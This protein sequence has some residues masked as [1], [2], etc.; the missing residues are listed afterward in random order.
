MSQIE[1]PKS[2][3]ADLSVQATLD[4][5]IVQRG[6][7]LTVSK[8]RESLGGQTDTVHSA[9]TVSGV[10]TAIALDSF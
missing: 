7:V 4:G 2:A 9:G 6:D 5:R 8:S 3:G 1:C 10:V